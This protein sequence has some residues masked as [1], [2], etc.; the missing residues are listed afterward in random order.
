MR[1]VPWRR[2][3][4]L[5]YGLHNPFNHPVKL[6]ACVHTAV[7]PSLLV[8]VVFVGFQASASISAVPRPK[9]LYMAI[10]HSWPVCHR[11]VHLYERGRRIA[12]AWV[13]FPNVNDDN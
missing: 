6:R 1:S 7:L 11:D 9:M 12:R 10:V 8:R 13:C 3:Y 2:G 5:G 4:V